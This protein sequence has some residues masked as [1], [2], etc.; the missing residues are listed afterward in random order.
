[1]MS[2][3]VT[4]FDFHLGSDVTNPGWWPKTEI[5]LLLLLLLMTSRRISQGQEKIR[6]KSTNQDQNSNSCLKLNREIWMM[7]SNYFP[8]ISFEFGR[9]VVDR[10]LNHKTKTLS[11]QSLVTIANVHS[12]PVQSRKIQ[13]MVGN[14]ALQN[15]LTDFL[16]I[17]CWCGTH[18]IPPKI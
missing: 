4:I 3:P 8:R 18:G 12:F 15:L 1:M 14:N 5:L 2:L 9:D 17:W 11:Q 10:V 6:K 7:F 13:S 16:C